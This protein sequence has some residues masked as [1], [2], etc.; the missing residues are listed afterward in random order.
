MPTCLSSFTST[1]PKPILLLILF[2]FC[3]LSPV[4]PPILVSHEK[5]GLLESSPATRY[6]HVQ[7]RYWDHKSQDLQAFRRAQCF[8]AVSVLP[9]EVLEV[10][11]G[12]IQA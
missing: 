5:V 11:S 4:L 6:S 7:E 3:P 8:V 9:K 12:Y 1:S 10:S 2:L